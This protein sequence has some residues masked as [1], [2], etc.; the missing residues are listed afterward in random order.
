MG[1]LYVWELP[2]IIIGLYFLARNKTRSFVLIF[3]WILIVLIPAGTARET[4]HALRIISILP[5]F[6]I[7]TAYGL[8]QIIFL[9]R[10]LRNSYK[11][12][13]ITVFCCVMIMCFFYYLHAYYVHFPINWSGEWQYGYKEMVNYVTDNESKYDHIYVTTALGRPYIFFAFYNRYPLETM[14]TDKIAA[15]DEFG[16][17]DVK[18][19]GKISFGGITPGVTGRIM[20]VTTSKTLPSDFHQLKIIRNLSGDDVFTIGEKI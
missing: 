10:K 9:I 18:S 15:K 5:T 6:Q 20:V 8:Y 11:Y 7:V 12:S 16:F 4:P 17:W 13:L 19:I 1:Q 3:L 2:F 14:T